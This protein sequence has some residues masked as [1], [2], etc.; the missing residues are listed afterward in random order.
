MP[1]LSV[2]SA[3]ERWFVRRAMWLLF[4]DRHY[5]GVSID[6][7]TTR[8]GVALRIY[9]PQRALTGA[10]L[11]WIHGGGMVV[12]RAAQDDLFC[13]ETA[14]DLGIIVVSTDYR[15][16]PEHPFP[17]ALDDCYAAWAWLQ[18][19]AARLGIDKTRVAVGGESAGGGLAASLAQRLHDID[20]VQPAAQWLICPMLD[21][22]T[23][24]RHELDAL[25]HKIFDNRQNRYCWRAF[26]AAEPGA[27]QV[28]DYAVPARRQ[29]VRGLPPAWIGVGDIE[30]FYEEDKTYADR[31]TAAGVD[32]TF[33]VVAGAP[34]GFETIARNTALAQSYLSRA[35][36]WLRRTLAET[37]TMQPK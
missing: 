7:E 12:G 1:N 2:T 20:G 5:D 19:S 36:D 28:P 18:D 25:R 22:R 31:L 34:H 10:A 6:K 37:G 23:A 30:L 29:D 24:A 3:L 9:T 17:A 14:R 35:R 33:D 11:L 8:Q 27:A 15:L 16:A 21:D 4:R 32:C 26:L 13:V